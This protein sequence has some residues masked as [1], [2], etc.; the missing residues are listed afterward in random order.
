MQQQAEA[1]LSWSA[2][3]GRWSSAAW[4][5]GPSWQALGRGQLECKARR[6]ASVSQAGRQAAPLAPAHRGCRS[7]A[8]SARS[9]RRPGPAGSRR[10]APGWKHRP[11]RPRLHVHAVWDERGWVGRAGEVRQPAARALL[12][13][14]A[15]HPPAPPPHA[16]TRPK[17]A[18]GRAK[19][20]AGQAKQ[21]RRRRRTRIAQDHRRRA[22]AARPVRAARLLPAKQLPPHAVAARA[23]WCGAG[24]S[25]A[26]RSGVERDGGRQRQRG[27][28][29]GHGGLSRLR[30]G[31]RRR[32]RLDAAHAR[33][34]RLAPVQRP[35]SAQAAPPDGAVDLRVVGVGR[36][37]HDAHRE[38]GQLRQHAQ[39]RHRHL[40]R[41]ESGGR[42]GAA[43]C[44]L[45]RR[46]DGRPRSVGGTR[47]SR[48]EASSPPG[49]GKLAAR[50]PQGA[51]GRTRTARCSRGRWPG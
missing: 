40:R 14:R 44:R 49:P 9:R 33:R 26:R 10:G 36:A 31:S 35:T 41:S 22:L 29:A 25:E 17:Q 43:W 1:A 4:R 16:S 12:W 15:S 51:G 50:A 32:C 7:A 27:L 8:R 20:A 21:S 24:W 18:T 5:L 2:G 13:A 45:V 23:V 48:Q 11:H 42:R 19:Q 39:A 37:R 34:H 28:L 38:V 47:S 46:G 6:Q 30:R 3:T